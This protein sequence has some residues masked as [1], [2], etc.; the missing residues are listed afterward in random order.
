V[1]ASCGRKPQFLA[2]F[3]FRR[4][5]YQH[6]FTDEVQVWCAKADRTSTITR[7]ISSEC[8]HCVGFR[9]P[10]TTI[11]GKFGLWEALY[12]PPYTDEC[13]IWYDIADPQCTFTCQ[14]SSR[15]VYSILSPS[16]GKNFFA[17]FWISA[18]T[19]VMSTV[20]GNLRQ[21]NT[22]AQLQTFPYPTA[23]KSFLYSN[24]FMAK[25]G[26]QTLTFKSVT[27]HKKSDGQTKINVFRHLGG[28]LNPSPTK[29]GMVIEDLEHVLAPLKRL[30][31]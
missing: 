23:S 10:K 6:P 26:E 5:L 2:N 21:L 24:A 28:G 30:G 12:R 4:L 19:V 9:W 1:S 22:G 16:G 25:S 17:V 18:F 31:V 3:D 7:Q 27:G 14:N 13:L 29:L 8:V 11:L 20:G 15:S